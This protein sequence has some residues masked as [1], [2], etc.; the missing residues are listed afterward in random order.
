MESCW[1]WTLKDLR[2]GPD[3]VFN[4]DVRPR[5]S[6]LGIAVPVTWNE[7]REE[8]AKLSLVTKP[9]I[10]G[11]ARL[12]IAQSYDF[13]GQPQVAF[14]RYIEVVVNYSGTEWEHQASEA[15]KHI[16][17]QYYMNRDWVSFL[18]FFDTYPGIF[19]LLNPETRLQ[20][21]VAEGY[22]AMQLPKQALTWVD[23]V[24]GRSPPP[25]ILEEALGHKVRLAQQLGNS[26]ALKA[27]GVAYE[28]A[29]PEGPQLVEVA[30]SLANLSIAEQN[31]SGAMGHYSKALS[32]LSLPEDKH[33][34]W[35]QIL[36]LYRLAGQWEKTI[37][38]Y[39]TLPPRLWAKCRGCV[40]SRGYLVRAWTV[41][42]GHR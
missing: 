28:N 2:K 5:L 25:V 27:A 33:E 3:A 4:S 23:R 41:P 18:T 40:S 26:E 10:S 29:F 6:E 13:E 22:M 38:G 34:M 11:M 21:K 37:A 16:L 9:E 32:R 24:I 31:Y 1:G 36:S 19:A 14:P 8:A 12:W 30:S 42:R 15:I 17:D 35:T 39:R 7:F 20:L